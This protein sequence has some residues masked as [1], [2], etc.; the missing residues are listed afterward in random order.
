MIISG[1]ELG[2][3]GTNK[4]ATMISTKKHN[5]KFNNQTITTN[6]SRK[7]N[8]GDATKKKKI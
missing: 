3:G 2:P 8:D 1:Q 6:M 7:E 5:E 4:K